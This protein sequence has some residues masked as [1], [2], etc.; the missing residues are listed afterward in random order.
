M[1][2]VVL[3]SSALLAFINGEPGREIIASHLPDAVI[4]AVNYAEVVSKLI[5]KGGSVLQVTALLDV[6]DVEVVAFDQSQAVLAGNLILRTKG[7][8]LS[9]GDRA[10]LALASR[11][12]ASAMTT[13]RI[14][15]KAADG[16]GIAVQVVR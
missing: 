16:T 11:E 8:G 5:A 14:W 3:D 10:C 2:R 7:F 1:A 6:I 15:E 12:S 13:D 4:S 9:L